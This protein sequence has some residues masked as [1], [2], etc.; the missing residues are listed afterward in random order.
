MSR[1]TLFTLCLIF[2]LVVGFVPAGADAQGISRPSA[3]TGGLVPCGTSANPTP[4][5]PCHLFVLGQN[6]LLFLWWGVSIPI[7]TL[8]FAYAGFLMVVPSQQSLGKGK[9]VLSNTI[10]GILITFT[11]W[12]IVDTVIKVISRQRLASGETGQI[13]TAKGF[14]PWNKIE[15]GL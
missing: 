7:A 9:K 6:I 13:L 11:A 1:F 14:G 15:C 12:L 2:I 4:C 5:T 8:M 3:P 10:I